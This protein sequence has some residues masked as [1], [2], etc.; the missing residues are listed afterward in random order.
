MSSQIFDLSN[1]YR[2]RNKKEW[3]IS[4][5][6]QEFL[7][8]I[9]NIDSIKSSPW[10]LTI[11]NYWERELT[12]SVNWIRDMNASKVEEVARAQAKLELAQR[13]LAYL[14]WHERN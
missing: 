3:W 10:Y 11:K 6:E 5:A 7:S 2:K 4:L 1:E 12:E 8:K 9:D 13:F 14:K